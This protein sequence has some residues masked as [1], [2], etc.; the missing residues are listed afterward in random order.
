MKQL[1]IKSKRTKRILVGDIGD[2]DDNKRESLPVVPIHLIGMK[3]QYELLRATHYEHTFTGD[4]ATEIGLDSKSLLG[5]E[6]SSKLNGYKQQDVKKKLY[7]ASSFI[8]IEQLRSKLIDELLTCVFCGIQVKLLYDKVRDD[9][10]WTLDRVDNDLG[11]SDSNTRIA[12]MKCNLQRR[13]IDY[14]KFQWTKNLV[15]TKETDNDASE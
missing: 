6:L 4:V 3:A 12:C 9:T 1:V 8:T 2:E 15:I 5:R 13:R 11:H 10:Q 14:D 7:D